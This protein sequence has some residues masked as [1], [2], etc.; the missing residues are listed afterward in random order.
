MIV[1]DDDN[2]VA[3]VVIVVVGDV[4]VFVVI[5]VA[6]GERAESGEGQKGLVCCRRGGMRTNCRA[7]QTGSMRTN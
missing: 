7:N 1:V 2:I 3:I 5:I 6:V 4:A